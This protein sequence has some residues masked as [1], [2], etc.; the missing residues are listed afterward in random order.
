[1]VSSLK[2][3]MWRLFKSLIRNSSGE[4]SK[5]FGLVISAIVGAIIGLSTAFLLVWDIVVDGVIDTDLSKLGIFIL[6]VGCY[7]FGSGANKMLSEVAGGEAMMERRCRRMRSGRR[8][9]KEDKD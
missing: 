9:I 5:S 8:N 1:M 3:S 7:T 6:C 4:S 2:V